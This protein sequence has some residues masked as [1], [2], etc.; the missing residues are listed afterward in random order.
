MKKSA[1]YVCLIA[2]ISTL[3]ISCEKNEPEKE[4]HFSYMLMLSTTDEVLSVVDITVDTTLFV[5]DSIA[6]VT[7]WQSYWELTP[8]IVDTVKREVEITVTL[9]PNAQPNPKDGL[10]YYGLNCEISGNYND[11]H[12]GIADHSLFKTSQLDVVK[13]WCT[14]QSGTYLLSFSQKDQKV[15][16]SFT[17]K[18]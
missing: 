8:V 9:K 15:R 10:Y 7:Y 18:N 4:Q 16:P 13:T 14:R 1:W 12:Y 17:K 5:P 11:E 2:I 6:S 3:C